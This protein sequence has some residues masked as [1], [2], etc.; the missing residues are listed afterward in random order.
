MSQTPAGQHLKQFDDVPD[1]SFFIP[2]ARAEPNAARCRGIF[3]AIAA[4]DLPRERAQY[5]QDYGLF[6]VARVEIVSD[7]QPIIW[8]Q[9]T[10]SV[11][12]DEI[13]VEVNAE[14]LFPRGALLCLL[15]RDSSKN[16][17][18]P[19]VMTLR[20]DTSVTRVAG[21]GVPILKM[22]PRYDRK[23]RTGR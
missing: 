12:G 8:L 14:I 9:Q 16:R 19:P 10:E 23:R 5:V 21:A 4:Q 6:F 17:H 13:V 7:G 1:G 2:H 11:D 20:A 15:E 22:R 3:I 18:N